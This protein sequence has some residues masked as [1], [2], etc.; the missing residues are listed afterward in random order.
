MNIQNS[1]Y[2]VSF[3]TKLL[4]IFSGLTLIYIFLY[5]FNTP[6][7]SSTDE[8][9]DFSEK[10][11]MV[12]N[13]EKLTENKTSYIYYSQDVPEITFED[14][15]DIKEQEQNK[16]TLKSIMNIF[17][18][19]K[20]EKV[21]S[22]YANFYKYLQKQK[23]QY[24]SISL[25]SQPFIYLDNI[26]INFAHYSFAPDEY[27]LSLSGVSRNFCVLLLENFNDSEII[28]KKEKGTYSYEVSNC[29]SF[30]KITIYQ[31]N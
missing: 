30:S 24:E 13:N 4:I 18:E 12:N 31:K 29:N 25:N 23:I 26:N 9:K 1:F 3:N 11:K 19:F 21:Y 22:G 20:K 7:K 2:K 8:F 28:V 14:S 15:G 5:I 6:K 16:K 10:I 27:E 17:K